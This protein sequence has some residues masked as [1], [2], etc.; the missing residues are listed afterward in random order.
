MINASIAHVR[1]R[2]RAEVRSRPQLARI[3]D[4]LLLFCLVSL[5]VCQFDFEAEIPPEGATY[6][7]SD[8]TSLAKAGIK[9][10]RCL[11]TRT[12]CSQYGKG[13]EWLGR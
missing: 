1:L 13:L 7:A 2:R 8:I 5:F 6:L 11:A 3:A 4:N 9:T 12:M 10:V